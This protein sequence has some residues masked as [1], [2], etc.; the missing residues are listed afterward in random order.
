MEFL[1]DESIDE[2]E[3][4]TKETWKDV[5]IIDSGGKKGSNPGDSAVE[6]D[7]PEAWSDHHQEGTR[8][9][10]MGSWLN[11]LKVVGRSRECIRYQRGSFNFIFFQRRRCC[12]VPFSSLV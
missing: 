7:K 8:K 1:R 5:S 3:S 2:A 12:L 11:W 10:T 6:L 9:R 4:Q